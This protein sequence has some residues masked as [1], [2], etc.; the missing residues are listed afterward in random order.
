MPSHAAV[1]PRAHTAPVNAPKASQNG[2]L[3][4]CCAGDDLDDLLSDDIGLSSLLLGLNRAAA[5][6]P[7]ARK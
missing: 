4:G 2:T 6:K 7:D 3:H 1:R 5:T